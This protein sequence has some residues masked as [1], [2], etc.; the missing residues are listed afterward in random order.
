[1][2]LRRWSFA[3]FLVV[4]ALAHATSP[5]VVVRAL[6]DDVALPTV[7]A[8]AAAAETFERR[9]AA[10]CAT[11]D[12]PDRS[13]LEAAHADLLRAFARL[14]P[15]NFGPLTTDNRGAKLAFW[16]DK[17]N[18]ASRQVR[19]ALRAADPALVTEDAIAQGSVALQGLPAIEQVLHAEKAEGA[20]VC[21]FL[22]GLAAN[23][24][25]LA[26]EVVRDWRDFAGTMREAQDQN[27]QLVAFYRAV[28]DGLTRIVEL[29]IERPLG[30]DIGSAR[31]GSAE[32]AI[33]GL[34]V[35]AIDGNLAT[36]SALLFGQG[37]VGLVDALPAPAASRLHDVLADRLAVARDAL[38]GLDMPLARA[39]G[40]EEARSR[41]Q[42]ARYAL[43]D[44]EKALAESLGPALGFTAGFNDSDGD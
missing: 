39:V 34:S 19:Q 9:R 42:V 12:R 21:A 43:N 6:V 17:H 26:R 35:A 25:R 18:V 28:V 41:V 13:M 11:P 20:F 40:D 1:M 44:V 31:G 14:E 30:D 10:A 15:L 8:F 36:I 22:A 4:P 2:N 3:V 29:K 37:D 32:A 24:E 27:E 5:D 38:A 23:V 7:R 16:P 33:S